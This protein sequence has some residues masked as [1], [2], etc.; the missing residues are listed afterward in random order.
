MPLTLHEAREIHLAWSSRALR[1]ACERGRP[2]IGGSVSGHCCGRRVSRRERSR[3]QAGAT[4]SGTSL[5]S[6][7]SEQTNTRMHVARALMIAP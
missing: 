6:G 4:R 2:A 7:E 5:V 3:L 1:D